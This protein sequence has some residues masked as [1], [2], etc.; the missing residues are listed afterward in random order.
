MVW[1]FTTRVVSTI[2]CLCSVYA[3]F[4]TN[5][6]LTTIL[7]LL[8]VMARQAG[9]LLDPARLF[10]TIQVGKWPNITSKTITTKENIHNEETLATTNLTNITLTNSTATTKFCLLSFKTKLNKY[11]ICVAY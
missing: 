3:I 8:E 5:T 9:Q 7:Y 6:K 1:Y 11:L 2:L 10:L 4:I